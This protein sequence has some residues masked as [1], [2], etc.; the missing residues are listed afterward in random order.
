M[1]KNVLD[2]VSVLKFFSVAF[3]GGRRSIEAA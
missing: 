1:V 3:A 2:V